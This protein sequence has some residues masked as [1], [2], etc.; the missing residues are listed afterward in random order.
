MRGSHSGARGA[1][2]VMRAD[3]KGNWLGLLWTAPSSY[4][5]FSAWPYRSRGWRQRNAAN[6]QSHYL[7]QSYQDYIF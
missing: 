4:V 7:M 2:Q 1:S 5:A 3:K 6:R